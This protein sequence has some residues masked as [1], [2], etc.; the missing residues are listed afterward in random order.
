M[1]KKKILSSILSLAIAVSCVPAVTAHASSF[2][3][4][5]Y[6]LSVTDAERARV[7][8]AVDNLSGF[9]GDMVVGDGTYDPYTLVGGLAT[10]SSYDS[11]SYGKNGAGSVPTEYPFAVP[12]TEKN[13]NEGARKTAKYAS[14]LELAE[15]LGF[16]V[17]VQRQEDKYVYV[18]I[19]DPDAPEMVMALSHLDSPTASNNASNLPLWRDTEG[20]FGTD[21]EAYHTP[22]VKDGWLYGAGVQDDSGPTLATLFAAKALM[23]SGVKFD[24]RIRIVMGSYEDG[25]PGT[26]SID[27]TLA[28]MD[29]P[30]Y[31]RNPS[32]YDNWAYKSLNREETPI[33]GYT[34]DSRFPVVVGNSKPITPTLSMDLSADAEKPF[35]LVGATAGVTLREGDETLKYIVTGSTTQIASRAIFTLDVTGVEADKL[36][37]FIDSVESAAEERGWLPTPEGKTAKV[38]LTHDEDA[39]TLTLEVNTDVAMEMPM[40]QYGKNAIVWGMYLLSQAFEANNIELQ[41]KAAAD[42]IAD[43][44]FRGCEEGDAYIGAYMG[45]DKDLLRNPDSGVPNLTLALMGGING[46]TLDAPA[47]FY[48]NGALSIPLYIRSMHTNAA[49]YNAAMDAVVE[50]W[51]DKGFQWLVSKME[52]GQYTAFSNPTLYTSHD[53]PLV[54]MQYASY[55]ASIESDPDAFEGALDL[56]D[57]SSPVGTTGGT[58]ASNYRNKMTA[59]GA[60]IPGNERWWHTANERIEV[61]A[62]IQMTKLMADGM[63]EMARYSES[64]GAQLMWANIPGLNANRAE[65]DLLDITVGTYKDASDKISAQQLGNS[66]LVGA[67]CFDIPMWKDR[68]NT[69]PTAAAFEAGHGEGGVYLPLD[70]EDFLNSTYVMPMRLEFKF[71]KPSDMTRREWNAL[72]ESGFEGFTF[73]ILADDTVVPLTVPEGADASKFFSTRMAENDPTTIYAAVNLAIIDA[74]YEGVTTVMADSKTDLFKL[75]DEWLANNENPFP[76][77][78]AIEERGFFLFGDGEKNAR[79]GSPDAIYVTTE[80]PDNSG[81]GSSSAPAIRDDVTATP[82]QPTV[83]NKPTFADVPETHWAYSAV[84]A[85]A[86]AGLFNGVTTTQFAPEAYTTRAQ[87]MTVL[88]RLSG[89]DTSGDALAKGMA[90]AVEQGISDGTNPDGL[91]TREQLATMLYRYAG[92]PAVSGDLA[93][94]TDAASVSDWAKDAMVWAVQAGIIKG[95]TENTLVPAAN[96]TRAQVAAMMQRFAGL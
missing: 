96:A 42:G 11:I 16:E 9:V 58:L 66:I 30:Y 13:K 24:R 67:T 65:L 29:I 94:Y 7:H 54:A 68:G 72:V 59:F 89:A 95:M 34:S 63:L 25:N 61:E 71:E 81:S 26:P 62:I 69:S 73:N 92:K 83:E 27:D 91:I 20:N 75:N 28:Y 76:E 2:E 82:E 79:F 39:N 15:A 8:D 84:E 3:S 88:A 80:Q 47:S 77:R 51:H 52:E 6:E 70:N 5:S 90:W 37:A 86:K 21:P 74:P 55:V 78:G 23:D 87:M 38:A 56:L 36:A 49:D 19:G 48:S 43:L 41:L 57:V 33:A 14:V 22:Y 46:A 45:I 50:A 53:N 40:P 35:H 31:D 93:A 4:V 32:F 10:G 60:V 18:E 85:V 64:T 12:N 44:F 1:M 17:I